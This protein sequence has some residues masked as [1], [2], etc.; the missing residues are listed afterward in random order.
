MA[1]LW[2]PSPLHPPPDSN[3]KYLC[4]YVTVFIVLSICSVISFVSKRHVNPHIIVSCHGDVIVLHPDLERCGL[5]TR[6]MGTVLR[7][8]GMES[9]FAKHGILRGGAWHNQHS[10]VAWLEGGA[11]CSNKAWLEPG[12]TLCRSGGCYWG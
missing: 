7:G 5:G 4:T 6:L 9:H 8:T 12:D 3:N 10:L 1:S 2:D 11:R